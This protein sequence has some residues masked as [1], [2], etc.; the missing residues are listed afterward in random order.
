MENWIGF[1]TRYKREHKLSQ[2]KLAE[3]LG[4]T[5]GGVGH[6]LR[7]TRKPTLETINEALVKLGMF[8]LEAQVMVV[9]RGVI[10]E[11]SGSY[12]DDRSLPT[13]LL[14]YVSFRFPVLAWADL[15]KPLPSETE[16]YEQTDYAAEGKAYWL[17]VENDAMTALSGKSVS[18]GMLILVDTG[19]EA[20]HG[21]L[22]IA[23]Q[24]GKP[25]VFRQLIEDGGERLLRPLNTRY[26]TV[27]CE[28]GC[29]FLGVVVRAHAR[30]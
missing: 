4:M 11:S 25:A 22:V 15:Q 7:G 16:R 20:V 27:L 2:D 18:E 9:G 24:P 29:E 21:K 26:P 12:A 1:L 19:L 5:Q 6:W 30:L 3:R 28:E 17:P 13:E 10:G 8:H 23:R 14:R